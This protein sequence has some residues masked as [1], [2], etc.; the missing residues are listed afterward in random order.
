MLIVTPKGGHLGWVAG[1]E[2][3]FGAP[4][5]DSVVMEFLEHLEQ[6]KFSNSEKVNYT[7]YTIPSNYGGTNTVRRRVDEQPH[8]TVGPGIPHKEY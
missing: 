2:A 4:W 6:V 5:T 7:G 8:S 3:P 1:S